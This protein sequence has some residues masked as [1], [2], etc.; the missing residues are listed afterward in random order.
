MFLIYKH[1]SPSGKSYIGLTS[2]TIE[3]R[4]A[5]HCFQAFSQNSN[6]KFHQAIRKHGKDSFKS[7]ILVQDIETFDE[8]AK[9][10]IKFIDEFNT[11]TAGYNMT[12]GGRGLNGSTRFFDDEWRKNISK[13]AKNRITTEEGRKKR[14]ERF[15]GEGNNM[16]G[17]FGKDNPNY[18]KTRSDEAIQKTAEKH[19][20]MKRS[21]ET[22]KRISEKAKNRIV[23][24]E[25]KNKLREIVQ[26]PHCAKE[27]GKTAMARYHFDNCKSR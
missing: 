2:K 21:E 26:C 20:G 17:K 5:G 24:E 11:F 19:R 8:A 15:S 12:L 10:E 4:F 6:G 1:T 3:E 7:E 9:L 18:G 27:G 25:T 23:S 16:Y 14:S 13:S 22:R